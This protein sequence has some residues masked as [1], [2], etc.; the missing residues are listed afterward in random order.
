MTQ[1]TKQ[2]L[3]IWCVDADMYRW[4]LHH[5]PDEGSYVDVHAKLI[6]AGRIEWANSLL[7]YAYSLWLDNQAFLQQEKVM[8]ASMIEALLSNSSTQNESSNSQSSA[9]GCSSYFYN[10][11]PCAQLTCST[12]YTKAVSDGYCSKIANAGVNNIVASASEHGIIGNA[13]DHCQI[14]SS[15]NAA[16]ISNA[17]QNSRIGSSGT[18]SRISNA[19]NSVKLSSSGE[20]TRIANAGMRGRIGCA[21]QREKI[22]NAGDLCKISAFG[23]ESVITNAGNDAMLSALGNHSAIVSAGQ[24]T[25]FVL[26]KG[27]C[28][29][30][31]YHDGDRTRFITAYEG[32]NGI[33]A[34]VKYTLNDQHQFIEYVLNNAK[35]T[36]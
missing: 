28:A 34:G 5:F 9:I 10:Q 18:R 3:Q 26:G 35:I 17:G 14:A 8:T 33:Q 30:M 29:V 23:D 13:G 27:G 12:D 15:G 31:P 19:G 1:I 36:D 21:G 25:Y 7:E 16:R 2:M 6:K 11:Q 20:G 22:A 24:V 32:E 4:F